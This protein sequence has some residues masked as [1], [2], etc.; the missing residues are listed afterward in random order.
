[1]T[2]NARFE[3]LIILVTSMRRE[4]KNYVRYHDQASLLKVKLL[5]HAVDGELEKYNS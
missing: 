3:D 4:Q 2:N 5:E 1:M